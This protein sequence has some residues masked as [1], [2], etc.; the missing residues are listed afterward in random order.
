MGGRGTKKFS[1]GVLRPSTNQ[2]NKGITFPSAKRLQS[3]GK[4]QSAI[5][6]AFAK[7]ANADAAWAG[8]LNYAEED[9]IDSY[10]GSSY[11]PMNKYLRETAK[12]NQIAVDSYNKQYINRMT[13]ALDKA[14]LAEPTV[15][16]RGVRTH[17]LTWDEAQKLV[18]TTQIDPAFGSTTYSSHMARNW[19]TDSNHSNGSASKPFITYRISLPKGAKAA[20]PYAA[21]G[22][23]SYENEVIVQRNARY[24]ITSVSQRV[25]SGKHY[26]YLNAD[27]AGHAPTSA[28]QI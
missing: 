18:G 9:A 1:T 20:H 11:G 15:V 4:D 7:G 17:S 27:Y 5:D 13:E 26:I 14:S 6:A 28:V 12:G 25:I 2:Q 3:A 22:S 21:T 23:M 16:Y 24:K 19:V 8:K 10:Q